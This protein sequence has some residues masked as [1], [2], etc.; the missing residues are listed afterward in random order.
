MP[1]AP[2]EL[3]DKWNESTAFTQITENFKISRDG[4][5]YPINGYSPTEE[6]YSAIDYLILEWDY[7]YSSKTK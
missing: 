7:G 1:Q 6:D 2:K 5:I 3:S 4:I